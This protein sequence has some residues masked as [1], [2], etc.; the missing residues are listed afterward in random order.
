MPEL[1]NPAPRGGYDPQRGSDM[2]GDSRKPH[3]YYDRSGQLVNGAARY[4]AIP[5]GVPPLFAR[6]LLPVAVPVAS[7]TAL[8]TTLLHTQKGANSGSIFAP[9]RALLC[10]ISCYTGPLL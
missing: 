6:S 3:R 5:D 4:T 9:F 8:L 2:S 7:T 10:R 1:G